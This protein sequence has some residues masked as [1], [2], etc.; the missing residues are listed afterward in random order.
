MLKYLHAH[1]HCAV[2]HR[3][4]DLGARFWPRWVR[5]GTCDSARSCSIPAGMTCRP[6]GSRDLT[7][8]RWH[9]RDF[10]RGRN[11]KWLRV[12]YPVVTRCACSC[13]AGR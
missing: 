6:A 13:G 8:L 9:C 4:K 2:R 10:L 3:W 12:Q 5:A 7:L 11:C 1:T